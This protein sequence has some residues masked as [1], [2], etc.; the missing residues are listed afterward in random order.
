M[1]KMLTAALAA[2]TITA[3]SLA[4]P[5]AASAKP[6]GHHG[7]HHGMD[8][9]LLVLTVL[10]LSRQ[11]GRRPVFAAYL[12]LMFCYGVGNIANDFWIEQVFKLGW[13]T[14][15]IPDVLEPRLTIAWGVIVLAASALWWLARRRSRDAPAAGRT[16]HA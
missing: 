15:Q 10:L 16:A 9:V 7:H 5:G 8:G 11:V 3:A 13:T 6:G 4:I 14:W 1:S 2:L 12:S